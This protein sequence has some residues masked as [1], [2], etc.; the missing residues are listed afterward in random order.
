MALVPAAPASALTS[1]REKPVHITADRMQANE[2]EGTSHYVGDVYLKQGS[3]EIR[4]DELTVYLKNGEVHK[5][6]VLGN[7]ARLQQQPDDRDMVFSEALKMEY[8][9]RSGELLLIEDAHVK[10]GVNRISG[11]RIQYDT[12]NSIVAAQRQDS[13]GT[14]STGGDGRVRAIIE[15]ADKTQEP[16]K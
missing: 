7:P 13:N 16:A 8:D 9:T 10:Q 11:Q 12:R 14:D 4:S 6:I 5:I 3:L 1:D 15:P 2:R